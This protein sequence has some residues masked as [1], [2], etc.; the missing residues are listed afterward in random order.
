MA[1]D[2]SSDLNQGLLN[3]KEGIPPIKKETTETD[4]YLGLVANP[5]KVL[6]DTPRSSSSL[7]YNN[8]NDNSVESSTDKKSTNSSPAFNHSAK[9]TRKSSKNLSDSSSKAKYE[10]VTISPPNSKNTE[11]KPEPVL[12]PQQ[13]RIKRIE[14]LRKLSDIKSKGFKLSKEYDFNSSIE[15]M[16]YEYDLL[17]SFAERR[18]GIKLYKNTIMNVSSIIEFAN[19]KYDPFGFKLDGWSE[20][21]G[22][23]VDSY[24][25]VMEEL[26][27]K[28]KGKGK[29]MP[30]EIKLFLLI[31]ASGAAFHFSKSFL[32]KTP[33]MDGIMNMQPEIISKLVN[34]KTPNQFMSEQELNIELQRK[35]LQRK[36]KTM[37]QNMR[38]NAQHNAPHSSQQFSQS[39][40][41]QPQSN[42]SSSYSPSSIQPPK[43]NFQTYHQP[44][45]FG[46][47]NTIPLGTPS[48]LI[49]QN[50]PRNTI[51]QPVIKK[52][53]SVKDVLKRLHSRDAVD[54]IDTMEESTTNNDRLVSDTMS[55]TKIKKKK[56]L[57]VVT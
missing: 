15:E 29:S 31:A 32:S 18:N 4:L 43:D 35:D 10:K 24:D 26:Y 5:S 2:T 51:I 11:V 17:K 27:E 22:I 56:N 46:T 36:E 48:G 33:G 50:D 53:E 54:T 14:L 21:M 42:S 55:D 12:T 39:S 45:N 47:N 9:N 25:D 28:Y 52:N 13:I 49:Q 20:H 44:V 1:S 34:N 8:D 19:G 30:P 38:Y 41:Q 57:M 6:A 37:K 16:E 3:N 7:H 40:V 23:E